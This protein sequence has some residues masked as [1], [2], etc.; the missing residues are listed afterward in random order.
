MRK[1]NKK[2]RI[3]IITSEFLP[4]PG[5]IGNHAFCLSRGLSEKRFEIC[6][7]APKE[8]NFN[9]KKFDKNTDFRILRYFNKKLFKFFHIYFFLLKE[10][11]IKDKT[12]VISTGIVPLIILGLLF[13]KSNIKR[14]AIIHG[15]ETGIGNII[16]RTI[17]NYSLKQYDKLICV[18]KFSKERIGNNNIKKKSIVINNGV[19]IERFSRFLDSNKKREKKLK[20]VTLGSLSYR[21]GQ[22]NV[23]KALPYLKKY[24]NDICYHMIGPENIK[25]EL[26]VLA[27]SLKILDSI[28]FHGFLEDQKIAELFYDSD[29]FIMLSEVLE[30]GDVEGFGIAILEANFFGLPSIGSKDC[31]IQDAIRNHKTG[32]LV[33]N[34]SPKEIKKALDEILINYEKFSKY[35]IKWSKEHNWKIITEKYIKILNDIF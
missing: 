7:I 17:I 23:I 11:N 32:I 1:K 6:V 26:I 12:I 35:S 20:L 28:T 29:I 30:N 22:H 15:H 27:K 2:S 33:D 16:I 8:L 3:I 19:D 4:G 21:K 18:S 24:Y 10:L 25:K 34:H 31:G 13:K 14:L 5:G 9:A